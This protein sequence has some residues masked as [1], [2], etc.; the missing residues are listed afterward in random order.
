[1]V[2]RQVGRLAD[3]QD[4]GQGSRWTAGKQNGK[5]AECYAGGW[6]Q[7]RVGRRQDGCRWTNGMQADRQIGRKEGG[8][9]AGRYDGGRR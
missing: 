3:K 1:M 6:A 8:W 4:D 5:Q 2:T 7:R 9:V